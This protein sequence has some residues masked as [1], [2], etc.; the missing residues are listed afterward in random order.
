MD[1]S[2]FGYFREQIMLFVESEFYH[3]PLIRFMSIIS[4][5]GID[6][7]V[8]TVLFPSDFYQKRTFHEYGAC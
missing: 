3:R 2:I 5:L 6:E 8:P 1:Q 7:I 4:Y